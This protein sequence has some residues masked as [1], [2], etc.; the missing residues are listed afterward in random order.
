MLSVRLKNFRSLVNTGFIRL[1]PITV[2]VGRNSSGKS[3]FTRFLPLLRQ[4]VEVPSDA[5]LL[6]YGSLVDFG[7]FNSVLSRG[8]SNQTLSFEL[9]F[10]P[11]DIDSIFFSRDVRSAVE[12]ARRLKFGLALEEI[13]EQTRVGSLVLGIDNDELKLEL[14]REGHV[15]SLPGFPR[16]MTNLMTCFADSAIRINAIPSALRANPMS[17]GG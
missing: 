15:S 11:S 8:A 16:W 6:W 4:S 17:P 10:R 2:L 9:R 13:S 3:T 14:S 12:D 7:T 1:S 5:P